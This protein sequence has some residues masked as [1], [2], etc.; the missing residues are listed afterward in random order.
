MRYYSEIFFR[1]LLV[2]FFLTSLGFAYLYENNIDINDKTPRKLSKLERINGMIEFEFEK[3]RDPN[4]NTVPRER[5]FEVAIYKAQ[6]END[7]RNSGRRTTEFKWKER[8]PNNVS[9]RTRAF[10]IDL[11]DP[12]GNTMWTGGVAGGIWVSR[13]ILAPTPDWTPIGDFFENVAIGAIAQDQDQPNNI[14]VGTGEGWFNFDAV[15]GLGIWKT[16]DGGT[17]WE[18]LSSTRNSDFHYVNKMIVTPQ[19]DVYAATNNGLFRSKDKGQIWMR[20]ITGRIT[21]IIQS[22][23]G[24]LFCSIASTGIYRSQTGNL[25]DWQRLQNGLP[26]SGYRRIEIAAAPSNPNVLFALYVSALTGSVSGIYKTSDAGV[27][28]VP[29]FNPSAFGMDNFAR[30]Q[31][32]YDLTL[33]IDPNNPNRVFIGG[34][35]ILLTENAGQ[36]WNQISQWFGG[37]GIQYTHADQH[38]ILFHHGSSDTMYFANDGGIYRSFNGSASVPQIEFISVGYNV[39]QFYSCD[40]HPGFGQDWF[41]AGSQDNG[42][43][44]F[45]DRGLNNT[46]RVTGGDGGFVHIDKLNPLIQISSTT[47]NN[48]IITNAGWSPGSNT[49]VSI[50]SDQGYFI[51]PT[52]YDSQ[53]KILYGSYNA[54]FYS[55]VRN[56]GTQNTIDSTFIS[57]FSGGRV[58]SVTISPSFA[59][60]VYFG[61]DNGNVVRVDNASTA[62]PNASLIRTG[63]GFV[64]CVAIEESDEN[65][66]VVT[67]SN[68]GVS[69]IFES[70]NGG[71]SWTNINGNFPDMPVRW[72]VFSPINP[73]QVVLATE[74]GVWVTQQ[75]EGA[76]TKW[77][78]ASDGLGNTRIDM[79]KVRAS[80]HNIIAATHGRGL[81]SSD[82]FIEPRASIKTEQLISYTNTEIQLSDNSIGEF[83]MRIW[84]FGDGNTSTVQNPTHN[85]T[86]TG[87][88]IVKLT[89]DDNLST[90]VTIRILPDLSLPFK[91][92]TAGY[93][94]N[95]EQTFSDFGSIS[96]NGSSFELGNSQVSAKSGTKSGSYAWVL[97]KDE[98]KYENFTI[99]SIY[100]PK[101]DFSESGIYQLSFWAKFHLNN[102][103]GLQVEYSDDSGKT[104]Q[105]LGKSGLNK[106]YNFVNQGSSTVFERDQPYFSGRETAYKQYLIDI[107]NLAGSGDLAFRFVFK[108]G[109][110]GSFPGIAIDDFEIEKVTNLNKTEV[111]DL[112]ASFTTDR[113]IRM[114][115]T[116]FPE[117]NCIHFEPEVSVNGKNYTVLGK[118]NGH[119]F[120]IVPHNYVFT[121]NNIFNRDLYFLRLKVVNRNDV[122]GYNLIFYTD[123]ITLR[124][125]FNGT[126]LFNAFPTLTK[127][128]FG[129][130]FTDVVRDEVSI[131]IY[132]LSG[133]RVFQT[134]TIP[135]S[136]YIDFSVPNLIPGVY[137]VHMEIPVINYRKGFKAV[138]H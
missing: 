66:M 77:E 29:V 6:L 42:T 134:N 132:A 4:T 129:A 136:P 87:T 5:L 35:D 41:L 1:F 91:A 49:N 57:A 59:D 22:S 2:T 54:G 13:N 104:W 46:R 65:H 110:T 61:L 40:I 75:L 109:S 71:F 111:V 9:G 127:S 34:V 37:G 94:G 64:S 73:E 119:N 88:Y 137:V 105:L 84:D 97:A 89:L 78:P 30:D 51:N 19:G 8:G 112:T 45:T 24:T 107:S 101:F 62:S 52:G 39:T 93:S 79:L 7:I 3:T 116:T 81:Y 56:V 10:I 85:Y 86:D 92:G 95:F 72:A 122:T 67:Y 28:W 18:H 12:T 82:I 108:S 63:N 50:G 21:D 58:A 125:G 121:S 38:N 74:M 133:Q 83:Q 31:A 90:S 53:L 120:S 32:W 20:T 14:Y 138:V 44:L 55:M 26:T 25:N 124:R 115:W 102:F 113:K 11:N 15:R 117:Y 130:T 27:N 47:H 33:A 17:T 135:H 80:D 103:D 68:Y 131:S 76:L 60:R 98:S 70:K 114:N 16:S 99:A 43:Q 118:T 96:I 48:Y 100:T 123:P 69:K 23:D 36:N 128:S 126:E 106:W